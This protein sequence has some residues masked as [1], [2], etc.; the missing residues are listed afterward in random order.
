MLTSLR[1]SKSCSWTSVVFSLPA[2]VFAHGRT[3]CALTIGNVQARNA[4]RAQFVY[5]QVA[6]AEDLSRSDARPSG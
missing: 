6:F 5:H 4:G 3:P 1:R 2:N